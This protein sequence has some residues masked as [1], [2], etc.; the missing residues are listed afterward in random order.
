MA[1]TGRDESEYYYSPAE[2]VRETGLTP[3]KLSATDETALDAILIEYLAQIKSIIDAHGNTN[4]SDEDAVPKIVHFV[5]GQMGRDLIVELL[6]RRSSPIVKVGDVT[7]VI[8]FDFFNKTNK[9]LLALIP[10]RQ[11]QT[12][13][14]F[15]FGAV[16]QNE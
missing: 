2:I 10:R 16:F 15:Y 4:F 11:N 12:N 9:D 5:A 8:T 1:Y 13:S 14:T 3:Q 7:T 6:Q